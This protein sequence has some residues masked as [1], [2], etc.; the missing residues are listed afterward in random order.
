MKKAL[1]DS[2]KDNIVAKLAGHADDLFAELMQKESMRT[3]LDKDWL[4]VLSG[5]QALYNGLSQFHQSKVC[6]AAKN[7]GEEICCLQYCLELFQACQT[8]SGMAGLGGCSDWV[9]KANRALSDAKKDHL[10]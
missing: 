4:S 10:P 9:K 2:M 5:K 7:I 6:N 1:K 3:L 8:R